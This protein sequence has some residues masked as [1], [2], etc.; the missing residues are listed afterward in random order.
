MIQKQTSKKVAEFEILNDANVGS[1]IQKKKEIDCLCCQEV[2]ALNSK[3]DRENMSC[4]IKPIEFETLCINKPVPEKVLTGL[5][6]SRGDQMEKTWSN[7]SLR[8]AAY[9]PFIWQVF[10]SLGKGNG[11]VTPSCALQ[12]IRKLYPGPNI[13]K[14]DETNR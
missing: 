10:K 8:Y 1:V 14:G 6:K 11:K 5:Y 4:V 2:E 9:K 7:W 13:Q 12:R 3:F